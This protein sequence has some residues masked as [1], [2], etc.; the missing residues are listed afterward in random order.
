MV[1]K[2]RIMTFQ[3]FWWIAKGLMQSSG[4]ILEEKMTVL[5]EFGLEDIIQYSAT[6][7]HNPT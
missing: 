1:E 7:A 4:L 2:D 5:H 3:A 6:N